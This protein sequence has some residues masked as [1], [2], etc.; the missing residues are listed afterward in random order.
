MSIAVF[1]VLGAIWRVVRPLEGGLAVRVGKSIEGMVSIAETGLALVECGTINYQRRTRSL[2]ARAGR[3]SGSACVR[4]IRRCIGA[5]GR[6][7]TSGGRR[8]FS[9]SKIVALRV[10]ERRC[11]LAKLNRQYVHV[12]TSGKA[13][14]AGAER[15]CCA[16]YEALSLAGV[17][18]GVRPSVLML[19]PS[20]DSGIPSKWTEL[21]RGGS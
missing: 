9:A 13:A 20:V 21:R 16:K 2:L 12:H 5:I 14:G 15:A 1:L 19:E 11:W 4:E 10:D 18:R 7:E 6:C 8:W 17:S 3:L